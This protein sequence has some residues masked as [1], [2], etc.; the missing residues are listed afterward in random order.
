L[1]KNFEYLSTSKDNHNRKS[2]CSRTSR[3][4][5]KGLMDIIE[6]ETPAIGDPSSYPLWAR[7]P[8]SQSPCYCPAPS[9]WARNNRESRSG[10]HIMNL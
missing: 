1:I 3:R 10:Y 2:M 7:E 9:F 5:R 4:N 6:Q 8:L